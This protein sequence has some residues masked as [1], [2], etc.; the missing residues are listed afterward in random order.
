MGNTVASKDNTPKIV[1]MQI[2]RHCMEINIQMYSENM[3]GD[4][5]TER[6]ISQGVV[7]RKIILLKEIKAG[8]LKMRKDVGKD[9]EI[10]R[11]NG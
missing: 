4:E 9:D 5:R 7:T 8:I 6:T 1:L 2:Q 3:E 10:S 11:V